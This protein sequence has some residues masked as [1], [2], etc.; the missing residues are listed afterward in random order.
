M[1]E[2]R[3]NRDAKN[4]GVDGLELFIAIREGCDFSGADESEIQGVEEENN[5][6]ALHIQSRVVNCEIP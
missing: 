1:R 3:V 4:F 5:V 6:F 2:L